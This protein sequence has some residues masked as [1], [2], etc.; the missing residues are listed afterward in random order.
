M[1]A[2][3]QEARLAPDAIVHKEAE[4]KALEEAL[5]QERARKEAEERAHAEA[6]AKA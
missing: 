1:A 2:A 5:A 4:V 6:T 3:A